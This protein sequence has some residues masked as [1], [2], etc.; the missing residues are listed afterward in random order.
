M[1]PTISKWSRFLP[2]DN[3]GLS[4]RQNTNNGFVVIE[5][6]Y[7][8]DPEKRSKEWMQAAKSGLPARQWAVE[9]ERA[10]DVSAGRPVFEGDFVRAQ[11]VLG[12]SVPPDPRF[13][14]FRGWD[15]GGNQSC[16]FMQVQGSRVIVLDEMPNKGVNT[17]RFAPEVIRHSYAHMGPDF[18]Y[19]DIVDP[20][21]AWEGKTAEGKACVDVMR[22]EGLEP[23]AAQTNDPEKRIA[24]VQRLLLP[25]IEGRPVLQINPHCTMLIKGFEFGYHFPERPS[26]SRKMDRP[27]KNLYSHIHDAFQY[28]A[29]RL[30]AHTTRKDDEDIAYESVLTHYHWTAS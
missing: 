30:D 26:Q 4:I 5:L 14:I 7:F 9:Y 24:A 23:F 15:F 17:R 21:A 12:A 13:P 28:V 29:L 27:V 8:A 19:I 18:R 3:T 6:D 22:E 16:V 25:Y 11:H 20:S 2:K 1:K 10:W